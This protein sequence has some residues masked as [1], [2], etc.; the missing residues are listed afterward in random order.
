MSWE[1]DKVGV[2]EKPRGRVTNK[3]A[4][5]QA[6]RIEKD[7]DEEWEHAAENVR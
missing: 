5:G 6:A 4:C 2:N 3:G 1:E 7:A